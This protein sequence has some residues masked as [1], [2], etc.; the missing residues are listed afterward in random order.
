MVCLSVINEFDSPDMTCK[1]IAV[2]LEALN[3]CRADFMFTVDSLTKKAV[4]YDNST[5]SPNLWEWEFGDN[6]KS[7]VKNPQHDYDDAGFYGVRLAIENTSTGC[8]SIAY[9]MINVA[10]TGDLIGGF[11]YKADSASKKVS[12]YPVDFVGASSGDGAKYEWDFGDKKQQKKTDFI[13]QYTGSS[14]VR[15]IYAE[16][17]TYT[18][19]FRVSNPKLNKSHVSCQTVQTTYG[20]GVEQTQADIFNLNIYPNPFSHFA[21]IEFTLPESMYMEISVF[22]RLGRKLET[23]IK[24]NN[25]PGQ[26]QIIWDAK[27]LA[28]GIYHLKMTTKQGVVIKPLVI[29]GSMY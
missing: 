24:T 26:Y 14:I 22:D 11:T 18:A 28:P 29:A 20:I 1:W 5:G 19:C 10:E 23:L 3:S 4:F 13:V 7:D 17:G 12:G 27:T 25:D 16:P 15:Y 8:K 2:N 9:K 21:Y 6:I